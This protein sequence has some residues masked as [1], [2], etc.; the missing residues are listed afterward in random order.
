MSQKQWGI[1]IGLALLAGLIVI[2]NAVALVYYL[3]FRQTEV[4]AVPATPAP[5][6]TATPTLTPYPTLA[7]PNRENTAVPT[8]LPTQVV[9]ATATAEGG[10]KNSLS[11]DVGEYL[12][13]HAPA[14]KAPTSAPATVAPA[15]GNSSITFRANPTSITAGSCSTLTWRVEGV[16]AYW[17]DGQPGA[18]ST[19]SR[20]VCPDSTQTYEL[21]YQMADENNILKSYSQFVT[22]NVNQS[23]GSSSSS[24]SD[25]SSSAVA[26]Y[27]A[28]VCD[29][30]RRDLT[31][32]ASF[33]DTI[34]YLH[35]KELMELWQCDGDPNYIP[36]EC[37][38]LA[39]FRRWAEADNDVTR[40]IE[41]D[42]EMQQAG[43]R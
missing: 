10:E 9:I 29:G 3:N 13:E 40:V 26:S 8:P 12:A 24:S 43:C 34:G 18:G 35:T 14:T 1:V 33:N 27:K 15:A 17:V 19:G 21:K 42:E 7:L 5:T 36:S 30:Y 23:S 20:S 25:S 6:A 31:K 4:A 11:Q 39:L 22:V 16:K 32:Y 2:V 28:S 41:L 38:L 37:D